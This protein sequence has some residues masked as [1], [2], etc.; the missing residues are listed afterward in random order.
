MDK[1]GKQIILKKYLDTHNIELDEKITSDSIILLYLL[2]YHLN[3]YEILIEK[4]I[5]IIIFL[6]YNFGRTF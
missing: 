3:K 1:Y 6:I 4:I 2:S 5:K